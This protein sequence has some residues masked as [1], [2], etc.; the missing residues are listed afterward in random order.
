M[1]INR[2][3]YLNKLIERM[4]NSLIKVI[5]GLRRSGKS[6][7]LFTLFK[8]YLISKNIDLNH[9]IEIKLDE[10]ANFKL[11]NKSELKKYIYSKIIDKQNYYVLIDEIQYVKNFEPVLIELMR[12]ENVDIYVT[13]SNSKFLSTDID[14]ALNGKNDPIHIYPFSFEEFSIAYKDRS[15]AWTDFVTYG[16]LPQTISFSKPIDKQAYTSRTFNEIYIRDVISRYRIKSPNLLKQII[17]TIASSIGSYV[18][19]NNMINTIKSVAKTNIKFET[20]NKYVSH[21]SDAFLIDEC[22]RYDLKGRKYLGANKKYYFEDIGVR[23]SLI[24]FNIDDISHIFENIVFNELKIHD[25]NV[26]VGI[27][28]IRILENGTFKFKQIEVDFVARKFDKLYF[29]QTCYHLTDKKVLEREINSL[30]NVPSNAQKI[31]VT[32]D[33][34]TTHQN[35]QGIMIYNF[36]SFIKEFLNNN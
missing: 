14:T 5:T 35:E 20:I 2:P 36:F 26:D 25:F 10:D 16:S 19:I 15:K 21:L 34:V 18:S 8:F 13:G 4:N 28:P 27:I 24:N 30:N 22:N 12:I 3:L 31:I 23:N 7:L 6:F 11:R 32:Y 17:Q 29:I 1:I 33:D 9:I